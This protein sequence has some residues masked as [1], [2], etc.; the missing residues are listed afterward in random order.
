MQPAM[1]T[2]YH[3]HSTWSDG[4]STLEQ[5]QEAAISSEIAEW[6]ISDHI[7]MRP[8]GIP[9]SWSMDPSRLPSY[10]EAVRAQQDRAPA[11]QPLRLGLELDYFPGQEKAIADL[12]DGHCFDF[13]MGS[14][15]YLGDFCIDN[16]LERWKALDPSG[17]DDAW[18]AYF[19]RIAGLA[20]SG[21]FSFIAHL[22]LPKAFAF[23]PTA[24][25]SREIGAALDE[26]ARAGLAVEVN[27]SGW[28]RACNEAY[29]S[30]DLL[31]ACLSRGIPALVNADAHSSRDLMRGLDRGMEWLK[32]AGY[33]HVVRFEDRRKRTVAL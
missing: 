16:N 8:D 19:E 27:T 32:T 15:H 1:H 33:R 30:L 28:G 25:L 12:L 3:V 24:D 21:L 11:S 10:V 29:P 9:V 6:G 26:V 22:D 4:S 2:S 7:V 14:V 18:R 13:I 23:R 20:R 5:Y 31:G 17:V